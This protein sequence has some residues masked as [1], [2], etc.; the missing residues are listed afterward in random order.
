MSP[1]RLDFHQLNCLVSKYQDLLI[2]SEHIVSI[3]SKH[4]V[5]MLRHVAETRLTFDK[6]LIEIRQ[7]RVILPNA[8]LDFLQYW[9]TDRQHLRAI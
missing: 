5:K 1:N 9:R 3:L 2:F 6:Y 8:G 7:D 4:A